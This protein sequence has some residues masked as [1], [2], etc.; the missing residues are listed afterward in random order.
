MRVEGLS[1]ANLCTSHLPAGAALPAGSRKKTTSWHPDWRLPIKVAEPLRITTTVY[2]GQ[3]DPFNGNVVASCAPATAPLPDGKPI[4]VVCK[5]VE[6]ATTDADGRLGFGAVLQAGVPARQSTWT[7]NQ[8]GQVLT[9]KGPR[10]D[11][12]DTTT[13]SYYATSTVDYAVGDL[14]QVTNPLGQVTS[15]PK[16]NKHGQVLRMSASNGVVTDTTYDLRQRTLS[17]TAG[18][19]QTLYRYDPAGQLLEVTLP[20]AS[21]ITY[22]YDGARRL[23]GVKDQA[24]NSISYVLDNAGNRIQDQVRDPSGALARTV[25]RVYDALGRVQQTTGA[26]Q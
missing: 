20:D 6:Q 10:T 8:F 21:K 22:T 1:T 2:N 5:Q 13:Y 7:Y 18:G 14:N 15:Y 12:N 25:T 23:T 9:A 16:Y 11:V 3:P 4:V 24:G 19:L 17:T 26:P